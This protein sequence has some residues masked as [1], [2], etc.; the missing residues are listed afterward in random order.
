MPGGSGPTTQQP[1][2]RVSTF[3]SHLHTLIGTHNEYIHQSKKQTK[4]IIGIFMAFFRFYSRF[5]FACS[6]LFQSKSKKKKK[7]PQLD[8]HTDTVFWCFKKIK[9]WC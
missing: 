9:F 8:Q 2:R 4:S 5:L 6:L 1:R 3:L 7:N